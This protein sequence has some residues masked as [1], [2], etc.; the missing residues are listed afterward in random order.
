MFYFAASNFLKMSYDNAKACA[1]VETTADNVNQNLISVD[2][3]TAKA[4]F[5]IQPEIYDDHRNAPEGM[6][7]FSQLILCSPTLKAI[8]SDIDSQ[9]KCQL[10]KTTM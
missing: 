1:V 9:L 5:E 6:R 3:P 7:C 8:E 2:D 4:N 10:Q